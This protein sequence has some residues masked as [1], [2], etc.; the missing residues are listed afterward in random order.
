MTK[1]K[2]FIWFLVF[3]DVFMSVFALTL[4]YVRFSNIRYEGVEL[5]DYNDYLYWYGINGFLILIAVVAFL[6]ALLLVIKKPW[7]RISSIILGFILIPSGIF[8]LYSNFDVFLGDGSFFFKLYHLYF[9]ASAG[10]IDLVCIGYGI[11]AYIYFTR[12]N[13]KSYLTQPS[14]QKENKS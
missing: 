10:F 6:S 12:K 2:V 8:L 1:H 5:K 7:G 9:G 14:T 3:W 4:Y 11:F 13:V